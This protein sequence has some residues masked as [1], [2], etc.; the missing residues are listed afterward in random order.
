MASLIP[1]AAKTAFTSALSDHF[2]TFKREIVI[3]K[4]PIKVINN[5]TSNNSYAGYGES[6]NQVEFT[7]VPVSGAYSGIV[8]YY[9]N[10]ESEL[11]ENIGNLFLGQGRVKIKIEQNAR[12]FILNGSKTEAVYI[13]GNTFNKYSSERVQD[14]LGLKYYVFYLEKTD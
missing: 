6:S 7:Y 11:G 2:D 9:E 1:E 8:S 4:E 13:D 14:Y 5:V 3:F 10:Q 12:D